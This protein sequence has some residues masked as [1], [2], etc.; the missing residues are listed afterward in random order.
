ML[1]YHVSD[2][3]DIGEVAHSDPIQRVDGYQSAAVLSQAQC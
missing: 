1:H 2:V 3:E